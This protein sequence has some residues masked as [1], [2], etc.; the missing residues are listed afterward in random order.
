MQIDTSPHIVP[1]AYL[2]EDIPPLGG[3]LKR[4]PEDFI[5]EELPLYLPCGEGEHIYLMVEKRAM[6]AMEMVAAVARHFRVPRH[7]VGYA[8][9]KDKRAITRQIISVHTP[10]KKPEDFP[11]FTHQQLTVLWADLHTNKIR[12][13]HLA[14]NRF[15]IRVRDVPATGVTIARRVLERLAAQGVP[16]RFGEQRFGYLSNNHLI[17]RA[18]IRFEFDEAVRLLLAPHADAPPQQRESRAL[19]AEGKYAEAR[20]A[21]PR[22]FTTERAVLGAL[23]NGESA[24]LAVDA[25]EPE[26]IGYY[27][28]AFQSAV[29]N[30]VLDERLLAGTLGVLEPGDVAVGAGGHGGVAINAETLADEGL[31]QRFESF[32]L[33]P[34]GPMWG[35]DMR[36]ASLAVDEREVAALRRIGVS[37]E[38]FDRVRGRAGEMLGG[39]RRPLRIALR[40]VEVEG[41]VDER[42]SYVRCAFDLP[43]GA[44]AT[45]VMAEV[46]KLDR[47][48]SGLRTGPNPDANPDANAA[49]DDDEQAE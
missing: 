49:D 35:Y 41:G 2:T 37:I 19:F 23:A 1:A 33:S 8:G 27:H 22:L 31:R 43:R 28:S 30:A 5:V 6:T 32:I 24:E 11:S 17:G 20:E 45:A 7:A 18:L 44:F 12:R 9:L 36:R 10:G 38:D 15:S 21:M 16:D 46:M 39:T 4:K 3:S 42:G 40:N 29:F 34:S 47:L 14:G 25:I 48:P 26:I 13:G